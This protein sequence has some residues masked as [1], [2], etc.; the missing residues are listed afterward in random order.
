MQGMEDGCEKLVGAK[1]FWWCVM[2]C[3][4]HAIA[5]GAN[6]VGELDH[7]HVGVFGARHGTADGGS[8]DP[9]TVR[10]NQAAHLPHH[11]EEHSGPVHL[12]TDGDFCSH[13]Q[14]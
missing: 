4:G 9:E 2:V 11:D 3:L 10:P 8:A 12:P 7:G 5:C 13:V 14:R 6:V 1:D